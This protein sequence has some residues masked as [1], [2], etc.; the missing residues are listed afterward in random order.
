[1][2]RGLIVSVL[3]GVV[4][5]SGAGAFALAYAG[6]QPPALSHSTARYS[7]PAGDR[8]G[9]L[10]FTTEVNA[11]SGVGSV[12][13]LGWPASSSLAKPGLTVKEMADAESAVCTPSGHHTV[14][15]T[16]KVAVTRAEADK[17]PRGRWHVAVLAT[18]KDGDTT[19]KTKAA[20]FTA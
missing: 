1:M 16:Y 15:C 12:K 19:L 18:G 5:L 10:T 8:D 14:R 4:V 17:S 3:A 13:V 11:S 7:A 9:S 2:S 6:E 20:D